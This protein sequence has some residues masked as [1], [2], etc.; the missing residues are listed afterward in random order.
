MTQAQKN[1]MENRS[2]WTQTYFEMRQMN[3]DY[4]EK[5]R[6]KRPTEEDLVRYA[7][8]GKP[9]PL[10]PSDLNYVS[11]KIRW[12][13]VLTQDA[14]QKQCQELESL[15]AKRSH[16]GGLGYDD[17]MKIRTTTTAMLDALKESIKNVPA[18]DYLAGKRFLESLAYEAQ[19][20]S[21]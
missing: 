17:Q 18:S 4:R 10:S 7:A 1:E 19:R 16:S 15:F 3:R 13:L 9:K 14:Y 11:G 2:Q 20:T 6:G 8:M 21:G 12:P 5:E